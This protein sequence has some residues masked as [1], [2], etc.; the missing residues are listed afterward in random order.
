MPGGAT[1]RHAAWTAV[2]PAWDSV[3]PHLAV[4]TAIVAL[5][6][7]RFCRTRCL[8]Y[9]PL[10]HFGIFDTTWFIPSWTVAKTVGRRT[11]FMRTDGA[12]ALSRYLPRRFTLPSTALQLD[13][14]KNYAV[15][16]A[17]PPFL[18]GGPC[19]T[20]DAL[21][22]GRS[23]CSGSVRLHGAD[24]WFGLHDRLDTATTLPATAGIPPEDG[25]LVQPDMPGGP[26]TALPRCPC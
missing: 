17:T 14:W 6:V 23:F 4:T 18:R 26:G 24:S 3:F 2:L 11:G 20:T 12:F 16:D 21:P 10:R 5:D 15:D 25:C 8:F 13:G 7:L 22:T 9:T 19:P 1:T